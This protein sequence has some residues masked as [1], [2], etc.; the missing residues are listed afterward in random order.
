MF[1]F[2]WP[3]FQPSAPA[4]TIPNYLQGDQEDS[5]DLQIKSLI[6][7]YRKYRI[8]D[9]A[10]FLKCNEVGYYQ[11]AY[12]DSNHKLSSPSHKIKKNK[13]R[14]NFGKKF[15]NRSSTTSLNS[16]G[17]MSTSDSESDF[18]KNG[19]FDGN[20]EYMA[21]GTN[22]IINDKLDIIYNKSQ[23]EEIMI[24][25]PYRILIDYTKNKY[26][27]MLILSDLPKE[28]KNLPK[29][30]DPTFEF[31]VLRPESTDEEYINILLNK[32]N[33]YCEHK[34]NYQRKFEILN[35]ILN[36]QR[37]FLASPLDK[38][39]KN[40]RSKIIKLFVQKLAFHVQVERIF[41]ATLK[42]KD[43]FI[44]NSLN[45][46]TDNIN[47][48]TP[49]IKL[50]TI[51]QRQQQPVV[52]TKRQSILFQVSNKSS[53]SIK[54][55]VISN[56]PSPILESEDTPPTTTSTPT[57]ILPK[58]SSSTQVLSSQSVTLLNNSNDKPP[59]TK[60]FRTK[61]LALFP[62]SSVRYSSPSKNSRRD[63]QVSDTE[64]T[65]SLPMFRFH[66]SNK[67]IRDNLSLIS[68]TGEN[69]DPDSSQPPIPNLHPDSSL[70]P[71]SIIGN[72]RSSI[73]PYSSLSQYN[74]QK[75]TVD[76]RP[77]SSIKL[78][79]DSEL[80]NSDHNNS[81]ITQIPPKVLRRQSI[82]SSPTK[83]PVSQLPQA[84]S[85]P[86]RSLREKPS[87]SI[88]RVDT[89]YQDSPDCSTG[90]V[91]FDQSRG[92]TSTNSETVTKFVSEPSQ[93]PTISD[94]NTSN[95]N[96]TNT[97]TTNTTTS[98]FHEGNNTFKSDILNGDEHQPEQSEQ[99]F[100][101][102]D[103][104]SSVLS[105]FDSNSEYSE[106]R[107]NKPSRNKTYRNSQD[108]SISHDSSSRNSAN[109][110]NYNPTR[111]SDNFHQ[112]QQQH[113]QSQQPHQQTLRPQQPHQN[114]YSQ[115]TKNTKQNQFRSFISPD[116]KQRIYDQSRLAVRVRI[117]REKSLLQR[118]F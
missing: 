72:P 107:I 105:G 54:T 71:S 84:P 13:I 24:H 57:P 8:N 83:P 106:S 49:D 94:S 73:R 104:L 35:N 98:S 38:F 110:F 82:L 79:K 36:N 16:N 70:Q 21:D 4:L 65:I 68:N 87:F 93:S 81:H 88:I 92:V 3:F 91:S 89:E 86:I 63:S 90:D 48:Q 60:N 102:D 15:S 45:D 23:F 61:S 56:S 118:K 66:N 99:Q 40:D 1:K 22:I 46:N 117:E 10:P 50:N 53:N 6:Y 64:S 95:D 28:A 17:N 69:N 7:M 44:F 108:S 103:E 5:I 32:S 96:T 116:E 80:S 20:D 12:R 52:S 14:H 18:E 26:R 113:S 29:F 34:I 30:N 59:P 112:Q 58:I 100:D 109:S 78:V 97:E 9:F 75:S 62:S 114:S 47:K 51:S 77:H 31:L 19:S 33:I 2:F 11:F 111:S 115:S 27:S 43:P 39:N 85:S 37:R 41:K 25:D 101:S 74:T 76:T 42:T 55:S 67:T